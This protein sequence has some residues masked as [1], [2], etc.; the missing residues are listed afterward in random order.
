MEGHYVLSPRANS[1][2]EEIWDYTE[3]HW[4]SIKPSDM[5]VNYGATS[6]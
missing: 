3:I 5:S 1:D 4:A 2:L 6:K